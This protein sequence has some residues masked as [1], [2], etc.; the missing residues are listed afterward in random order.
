ML[1][2]I[3][4]Y[5]LSLGWEAALCHLVHPLL[6]AALHIFL[7]LWAFVLLEARIWAPVVGLD[8]GRAQNG[9]LGNEE[10]RPHTN[11]QPR[12]KGQS[13]SQPSSVPEP[14]LSLVACNLLHSQQPKVLYS[15]K[16]PI[17]QRVAEVTLGRQW[18]KGS[19]SPRHNS[20]AYLGVGSL[21]VPRGHW[22]KGLPQR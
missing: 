14:L 15:F 19:A 7:F 12:G 4:S 17:Q 8:E 1:L 16:H 20:R 22:E 11:W 18:P 3:G 5:H 9:C 2:D 21:I 13:I 6:P 10:S